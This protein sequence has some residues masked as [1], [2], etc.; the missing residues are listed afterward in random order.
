MARKWCINGRFLGQPVTGVQRYAREVVQALDQ[1]LADAH[2]LGRDLDV[3]LVVPHGSPPL[4]GLRM[5]RTRSVGVLSGQAW[6]QAVLPPQVPGGLVSLC[7]TGPLTVRRQIVCIHDA[8]TRL[9][10]ASY[11]LAFR[12]LYRVLLPALGRLAARVATV[13][14]YSADQL[15]RHRIASKDKIFVAPD[16]HEH[17]R[18]WKPM[19][20][21][22]TQRV[23]GPDT[24][25]VIASPAPH[26]NVALI[27]GMAPQLEAAGLKVAVAGIHDSRVLRGHQPEQTAANVAWLGHVSD[28]DLAALLRDSLCLA[29]PSLAEGFGLPALEAMALRC[30][31]VVSDRASLPEICADAALYAP[32]FDADAWLA[33]F[34]RLRDD[35]ELRE[36]LLARGQRRATLYSWRRT[37]AL[38]LEAM[39]QID[40]VPTAADA[41][42]P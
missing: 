15:V 42:G 17:V 5:I 28:A 16:G 35:A 9:Y 39:A 33:C 37:A 23:A 20:S 22:A 12:A 18:K 14:H 27:L 6:E 8:N 21:P 4:P 7:N 25:V 41:L 31:V 38:Y 40:A 34:L 24:V 36:E 10:P 2:P 19:H 26:K 32:P 13:S 11:S 3:E 30:P 1:H 29:F